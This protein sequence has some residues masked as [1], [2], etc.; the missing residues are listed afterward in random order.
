MIK[1]IDVKKSPLIS[2]L[3]PVYNSSKFISEAIESVLLQTYTN[4]EL[5][6]VDDAS[7]DRSSEIIETLSA[8]HPRIIFIKLVANKGPGFCRNKATEIAKGDYIAFLD[9][10]DLW[11]PNKLEVQLDFMI[12]NNCAVSFTSYLHIDELG[13]SLKKRIVARAIL[14]YKKQFR[15][16]YIG[17]L[18]GMYH[19]VSLGKIESPKIPKRQDWALWLEAIKISE[20]PARG[21]AQDLAYYRIRKDSVSSDKIGLLKHN[22][23]FYKNHLGYSRPASLYFM[24]CFLWEY[25][26]VR[27]KFIERLD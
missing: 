4:W 2:V 16:N 25:F 12:E 7:T 22:Y 21:I 24:S 23:N 6:I 3:M 26:F 27:P 14:P 5:I 11:S 20:N 9:S 1:R 13:N 18:T 10:D 17:N 8:S 19:A 15:N